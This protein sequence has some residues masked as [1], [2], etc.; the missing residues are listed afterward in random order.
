MK[1]VTVIP[2]TKGFFKEHLTYFTSHDIEMGAL[3]SVPVRKKLVPGLVVEVQ[4]IQDKKSDI[5]TLTYGLKRAHGLISKQFFTPECIEAARA[6][7]RFYVAPLGQVI[8]NFV[9]KAILE[10]KGHEVAVKGAPSGG[11]YERVAIQAGDE[12][13]LA[14]YKSLIREEFAKKRSVFFCA[15]T[16][17]DIE[18]ALPLL[19]KG[20]EEYTLLFHGGLTQKQL[21]ELW[22]RVATE[23]HP[24]LIVA[25]PSFLALPRQDF[26]AIIVERESSPYY[27][28]THRPFVDGRFFAD[29]LAKALGTRVILGDLFLRVETLQAHEKAGYVTPASLKFRSLTTAECLVVNMRDERA[30]VANAPRAGLE[31]LSPALIEAIRRAEISG[32]RVFL[33]CHRKGIASMTVCQDCGTYVA[34]E[35][36][37]APVALHTSHDGNFFLCHKCWKEKSADVSCIYCTSWRLIPLGIGIERVREEV[38]R[39]FPDRPIFQIDSDVVTSHKKAI[40]VAG[41][42]YS[43]PGAILLG[44]EMAIPYIPEKVD[45]VGVVSLDSLFGLPDFRIHEKIFHI[46]LSLRQKSAKNFILQTRTPERKLFDYIARGNLVDFYRDE[47][48][49]RDKF[50]YPPF[51]V[52]VKITR[53]GKEAEVTRDMQSLHTELKEWKP[54][55]FPAF[56]TAPEGQE[57][58][59][60]LLKIDPVQWPNER[61]SAFLGGLPPNYAVNV[62]PEDIL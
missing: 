31:I 19:E 50:N 11:R 23:T 28:S 20:I 27:K 16:L 5:K 22:N 45:T 29:A 40:E 42:F 36:C 24:I 56:G 38:A 57:R 37:R 30:K 13:R 62:D 60:A 59:H 61:L 47:L 55:V 32:G 2:I 17:A 26:G 39:L 51:K 7:A 53:E 25:T 44:T 9:P 14:Y 33:Y 58:M 6:T 52:L 48:I 34:C 12:E 43:T 4:S 46:G 18:L 41:A 1:L 21:L 49:V 35:R 8:K 3:I 54:L 15:P 10:T